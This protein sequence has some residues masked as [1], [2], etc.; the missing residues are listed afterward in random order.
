[1]GKAAH[2]GVNLSSNAYPT[3][4]LP[5]SP[6][7]KGGKKKSSSLPFTRGGLGWGNVVS[8]LSERTEYHVLTR[9]SR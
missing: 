4:V 6:P 8:K 9:V 7:W 1:M 5:L 2:I 3:D